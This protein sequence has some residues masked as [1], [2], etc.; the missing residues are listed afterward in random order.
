MSED[1]ESSI[2]VLGLRQDGSRFRPSDWV[3]RLSGT[4]ASYGPGRRLRYNPMV[5]PGVHDGV[6]CLV[7]DPKLKERDAFAF[8]FIMNFAARNDLQILHGDLVNKRENAEGN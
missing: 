7:V 3:D 6:K 4:F 2:V 1:H 5:V 8:N